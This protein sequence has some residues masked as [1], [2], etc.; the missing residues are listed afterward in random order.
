M[1]IV[2]VAAEEND[3]PITNVNDMPLGFMAAPYSALQRFDDPQQWLRDG[4][5]STG[6]GSRDN[7][8]QHPKAI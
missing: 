5:A 3:R 1:M 8:W 4:L 2:T 6:H 7:N